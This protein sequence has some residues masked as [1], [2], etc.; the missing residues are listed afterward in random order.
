MT[1]SEG[2]LQFPFSTALLSAMIHELYVAGHS[3]IRIIF[4]PNLQFIFGEFA[5]KGIQLQPDDIKEEVGESIKTLRQVLDKF[6]GQLNLAKRL[7]EDEDDGKRTNYQNVGRQDLDANSRYNDVK[8]KLISEQSKD[9]SDD[10]S[11]THYSDTYCDETSSVRHQPSPQRSVFPQQEYKSSETSSLRSQLLGQH[12]DSFDSYSLYNDRPPSPSLEKPVWYQFDDVR[13][14]D[15]QEMM[16]E[17]VQ[18][19]E[20]IPRRLVDEGPDIYEQSPEI[21]YN[22]EEIFDE[23]QETIYEQMPY[24]RYN[25]GVVGGGRKKHEAQRTSRNDWFPQDRESRENRFF[26]SHQTAQTRPPPPRYTEDIPE[27][28]RKA[29]SNS[30][31][32]ELCTYIRAAL[33]ESNNPRPETPEVISQDQ[34]VTDFVDEYQKYAD[35]DTPRYKKLRALHR[36]GGYIHA[37]RSIGDRI[38]AKELAKML[39]DSEHAIEDTI[40][41]AT[42][43]FELFRRL[44]KLALT[45]ISNN[46]LK[47]INKSGM[48]QS[49]FEAILAYVDGVLDNV[50]ILPN[51]RTSNRR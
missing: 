49:H 41:R 32:R 4:R 18:Q 19:P 47:F 31:Y 13:N 26:T 37:F 2:P 27:L 17:P 40:K 51:D 35:P 30:Q 44:G 28:C 5:E 3:S 25:S 48:K 42:W 1:T 45:S 24:T 14:K 8:N 46:S 7:D 50:Y 9:H 15:S 10:F 12:D 33:Q 34:F 11:T 6:Q 36:L 38:P 20:F 22:P 16:Y 29:L 39:G 23:P 21:I 43:M